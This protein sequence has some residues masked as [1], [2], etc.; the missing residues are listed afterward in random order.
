MFRPY[1]FSKNYLPLLQQIADWL[2]K[3]GQVGTLGR[4]QIMKLVTGPKAQDSISDIET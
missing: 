4:L 1:H 3:I 2:K